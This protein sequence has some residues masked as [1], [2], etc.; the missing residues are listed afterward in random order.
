MQW[1]PSAPDRKVI[2][3]D[4]IDGALNAVIMDVFSGEKRLLPRPIAAVSH[5]GKLAASINYA[6]LAATRPGYGYAGVVDPWANVAVPRDDGLYVMDLNTGEAKLI[7]SLEQVYHAATVPEAYRDKTMWLNHVVFSRDDKRI[8]FLG[9]FQP[10]IPGPLIT[11]AF[12]IAPDGA[13][14]RCVLPYEWGASHFDWLDGKQMAV[15]SKFQA[16]SK[17]LHVFFTDGAPLDTYATLA[18]E[19][20]QADGHCHFSPDGKWMVTDSYPSGK[21][22]M[23][24]LYVLEL[25][26]QK[27]AEVARFN[28]P[29]NFKGEWRC[30]LHPRWSRDGRRICIDSTHEGTR[31]LY[32]VKIAFPEETHP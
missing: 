22:R 8:F 3:N 7:A 28:E 4:R 26:T 19:T 21:Q 27:I 5:D 2:Y 6:R 13:A 11:A 14:L 16:G 30:D 23:Q 25:A 29:A 24:R 18:P 32:A 9:R 31:Q 17:W 1:L 10:S 15:V 20:L 12:T